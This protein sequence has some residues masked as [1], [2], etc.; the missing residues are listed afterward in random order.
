M[1][2]CTDCSRFYK[3]KDSL[4]AH[5]N[6]YHPYPRKIS[7]S[8][9][10]LSSVISESSH[11][12]SLSNVSDH[13]LENKIIDNKHNIKSL[14]W[15][16][17]NLKNRVE[18]LESKIRLRNYTPDIVNQK[19]GG[20]SE[21]ANLTKMIKIS[22]DIEAIKI[23]NDLNKG[24]IQSL[25]NEMQEMRQN[26]EEIPDDLINE[27]M[28]IR[29][30][31]INRDF[32]TLKKNVKGLKQA[33]TLILRAGIGSE[34]LS[35]EDLDLLKDISQTPYPQDNILLKKNFSKLVNMF[36]KLNP[37]F[38]D[39]FENEEGLNKTDDQENLSE[40]DFP[41]DTSEN[42]KSEDEESTDEE[43]EEDK[44]EDE[45]NQVYEKINCVRSS[46][47]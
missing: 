33:L 28:Q 8:D 43:S 29:D 47:L 14:D 30:L 22:R 17:N 6:R 21:N 7:T 25:R 42:E 34:I 19:A 40:Q 45:A 13:N 24:N 4:R 26:S 11:T 18:E 31:F 39:I 23:Q 37:E 36:I 32:E 41:G 2:E 20:I 27:M 1:S 12:S 5:R 10:D 44:T 35:C 38:D 9:E 46:Y 16:F 3:N 15:V